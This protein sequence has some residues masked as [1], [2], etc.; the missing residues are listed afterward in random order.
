MR[1]GEFRA[2]GLF[3]GSGEVEVGCK[4]IVAQRLKQSSLRYAVA[5]KVPSGVSCGVRAY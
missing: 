4:S 5:S 1:Y 2:R 3:I